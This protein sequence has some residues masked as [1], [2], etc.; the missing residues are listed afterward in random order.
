MTSTQPPPRPSAPSAPT[1]PAASAAVP[2]A[3]VPP[4]RRAIVSPLNLLALFVAAIGLAMLIAQ[5]RQPREEPWHSAELT[6]AR[7][8][9]LQEPRN[10]ELKKT[11]RELD[12]ALRTAYFRG[13][14]RDR[15]GA[16]LLLGTSVALI[17]LARRREAREAT[18]PLPA[19]LPTVDRADEAARARQSVAVVAGVCGLFFAVIGWLAPRPAPVVV[20]TAGGSTGTHVAASASPAPATSSGVGA[21]TVA[22][23]YWPRFRGA[24]GNGAVTNAT[25]PLQWEMAAGKGVQWKTEVPLPGYNSPVVWSNRVFLTGGTRPSRLVFCFDTANGALLWQR[26]VTPTNAPVQPVEPPDQSGAAASTVATDGERVYAVFAS[27]ELGALDFSGQLVWQ[28]RLDFSENGYGHAS[29][30]V[31]WNDRLLVQADQGQPEDAKSA[32]HAY[33]TRTGKELWSVKRPVGGS[34]ATP[35]VTT[36][37][38]V[39]ALIVAGNPLL[40]AHRLDTG[41]ELWSAKV[42]G[43]ELAPSPVLAENLVV[44]AS[45]GHAFLAV[46]TDGHGDVTTS[47]LAWRTE[48]QVPDVPSPV[49]GGGLIYTASTEGQLVCRELATGAKVWEHSCDT[50]FQASP[51]LVGERLYLFAQ[52]GKV[53]VVATG[54]EYRELATFELGEEVFATPA[55]AEDH[56]YLRTK[57]HLMRVGDAPARASGPMP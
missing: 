7:V 32:L 30:L 38:E 34:W 28:H 49:I 24:D 48:E 40:A 43:G 8:Q 25:L 20:A 15:R 1:S 41:A 4:T 22:N 55:V 52:P 54:R 13:L 39:P 51:L 46:K 57:K 37:G 16:W 31:V 9:L 14:E 23:R 53:L 29:S 19:P 10:E 11:I 56:L 18:G 27:G 5:W 47:H 17:W 50:E 21:A 33:D 35:I 36:L 26:P 45:P 2:V 3:A 44:V 12:L 42:L 6:A